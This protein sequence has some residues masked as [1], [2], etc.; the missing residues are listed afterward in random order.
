MGDPS[1]FYVFERTVEPIPEQ[2]PEQVE[3]EKK[4]KKS[5]DDDDE[6]E[7]EEEEEKEEEEI[8]LTEEEI[9]EKKR[10]ELEATW[11]R[12]TEEARLK[13][14]IECADHDLSVVPRGAFLLNASEHV[15]PNQTFAGLDRYS[16]SKLVNYVHA[17]PPVKLP[18]KSLLE[19]E[20]LSKSLD[21]MDTI[22][23]D[24]PNRM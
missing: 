3:D 18:L 16:S 24:V 14:F 19:Q 5:G 8:E 22:D 21:F 1:H 11:Y 20:H 17:R 23:E 15:V 12:A 7:A 6:E 13:Y 2:K 4:K 10:K 9:A